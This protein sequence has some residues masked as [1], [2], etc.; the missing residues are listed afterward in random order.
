MVADD[1]ASKGLPADFEHVELHRRMV[2]L[3]NWSMTS[4][5]TFAL[6]FGVQLVTFFVLI[7]M[8][9]TVMEPSPLDPTWCNKPAYAFFIVVQLLSNLL[10]GIP[11]VILTQLAKAND[12]YS[13]RQEFSTLMSS[14]GPLNVVSVS[15]L[16]K[17]KAKLICAQVVALFAI[18]VAYGVFLLAASWLK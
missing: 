11:N 10:I 9:Y 6:I 2:K 15:F 5:G 17:N 1:R 14:T 16:L 4:W 7:A 3:L 13:I 8:Y 18:P 12:Q